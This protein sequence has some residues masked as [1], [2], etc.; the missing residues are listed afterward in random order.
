MIVSKRGL[1]SVPSTF[2]SAEHVPSLAEAYRNGHSSCSSEASRSMRSSSTSSTTSSG[3]AS[4]RSIL[5]MHTM[6]GRSRARAFFNT[7]F[8]W[9]IVPSNASTSRMT[10]FTILRTRSTSPPKSAWPGVSTIL[11]LTP[12]Y[13]I[14]VFL[15]RIVMPLSRSISPESITL[16]RTSW[17]S[18]NTPL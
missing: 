12:S 5:L 16:S 18:L 9:G 6:T 10:P 4:G 3:L 2:G 7:N 11:I 15:E 13:S 14:A 8:V 17:L 1:R